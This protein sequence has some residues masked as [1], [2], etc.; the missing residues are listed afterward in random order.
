[1]QMGRPISPMTKHKERRRHIN[2]IELSAQLVPIV[3]MEEAVL[4]ALGSNRQRPGE[5]GRRHSKMVFAKKFDP[6]AESE[7]SH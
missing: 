5:A 2:F 3:P 7:T 4:N 6:F 1:M